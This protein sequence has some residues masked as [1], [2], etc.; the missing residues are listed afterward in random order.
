M[1]FGHSWLS[2]SMIM[3]PLFPAI[4]RGV[5]PA[6]LQKEGSALAPRSSSTTS[7]CPFQHAIE[8]FSRRAREGGGPRSSPLESSPPLWQSEHLG[9]TTLPRSRWST[10][11][12]CQA[13]VLS[14]LGSGCALLLA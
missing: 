7:A 3:W 12:I 11:A 1:R 10:P 14:R 6:A 13:H 8:S 5:K 9:R 2:C 4:S